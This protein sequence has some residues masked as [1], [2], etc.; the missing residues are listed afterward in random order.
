MQLEPLDFAPGV[1]LPAV[2]FGP[3]GASITL[4]DF[5]LLYRKQCCYALRLAEQCQI[6]V[7]LSFNMND[8]TMQSSIS[9]TSSTAKYAQETAT[10][11][12]ASVVCMASWIILARL[13]PVQENLLGMLC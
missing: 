9:S 5:A 7:V 4:D 10:R 11:A 1:F 3:L 8:Q 13:Y 6:I 12:I 2:S